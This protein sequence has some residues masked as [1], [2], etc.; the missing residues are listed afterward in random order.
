MDRCRC[1]S[2]DGF[3]AVAKHICGYPDPIGLLPSIRVCSPSTGDRLFAVPYGDPEGIDHVA[4]LWLM[5]LI[6][7]RSCRRAF[8]LTGGLHL[9]V[10]Y[11]VSISAG[12]VVVPPAL[13][14]ILVSV[15]IALH[16]SASAII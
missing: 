9:C 6:D 12:A 7:R 4:S 14:K 13:Q 10:F 5:A 1:Q 16:P 2:A 15:S 3:S 8:E 11:D